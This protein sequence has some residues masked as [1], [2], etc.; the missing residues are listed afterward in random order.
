MKEDVKK[1]TRLI[2]RKDGEYMVGRILY[3][4]ELRWSTSPN[5]AWWT[6]DREKAEFVAGELGAAVVLYNP[7]VNQ[8]RDLGKP[9]K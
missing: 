3:S 8:I 6:R 5:D 2:I 7:V 9:Q 1:A 4:R